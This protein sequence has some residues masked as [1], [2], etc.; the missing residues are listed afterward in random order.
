MASSHSKV[1]DYPLWQYR[2]IREYRR[3]L[4]LWLDLALKKSLQADPRDRYQA[5]SEFFADL[6]KPNIDVLQAYQNLPLVKRYPVQFWQAIAFIL[7]FALLMALA[8]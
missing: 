6:N 1:K 8:F 5:Y 4:P 7:F 3:D 2:S